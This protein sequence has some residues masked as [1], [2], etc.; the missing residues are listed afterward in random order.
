MYILDLYNLKILIYVLNLQNI[1]SRIKT[2][3]ILT[4][5][6]NT[7]SFYQIFA[8]SFFISLRE[9]YNMW[10]HDKVRQCNSTSLSSRSIINID[11]INAFL[12]KHIL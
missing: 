6:F 11:T 1:I 12:W 2:V 8:I 9:K 4:H 3:C 5:I 10:N 7:V